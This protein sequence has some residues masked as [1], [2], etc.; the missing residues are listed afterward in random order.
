RLSLALASSFSSSVAP[1]SLP[2]FPTR[3][4]SDLTDKD[5]TDLRWAL[6]TG[7]DMIALSFVRRP[8]DADVVRNIMEQEAVRLPLL[9]KIE[10]PQAV[11]RLP[12]IVE[13]FD[14]IM[15]A[16]GDLGVELPLEQVP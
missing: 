7:F 9:A 13:A 14:G 15:V 8:S 4:S 1:R 12:E 16:R 10:K 3:R 2:S 6:R 5:E 11:E